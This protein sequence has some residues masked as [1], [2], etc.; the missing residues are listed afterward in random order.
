MRGSNIYTDV[1]FWKLRIKTNESSCFIYS[2]NDILNKYPNISLIK[3]HS[4]HYV[5]HLSMKVVGSFIPSRLSY[6]LVLK[7]FLR[8]IL[9]VCT[10][11]SK[12]T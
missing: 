11:E 12:R 5:D 1:I 2:I 10:F 7:S 6:L 9:P 4:L 8:I 3:T